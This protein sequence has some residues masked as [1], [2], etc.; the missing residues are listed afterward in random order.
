[1]YHISDTMVCV[2]VEWE[3]QKSYPMHKLVLYT[4]ASGVQDN[5]SMCV[6]I[7]IGKTNG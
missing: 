4:K 7:D 3:K 1:M 5:Q 6:C 2:V